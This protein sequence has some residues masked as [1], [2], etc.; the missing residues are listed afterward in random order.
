MT[1]RGFNFAQGLKYEY[2]VDVSSVV[3]QDK[4]LIKQLN[5]WWFE[6]LW[7]SFWDATVMISPE[8]IIAHM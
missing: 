7:H 1:T 5:C 2:D 4:L 3:S 6:M 8:V